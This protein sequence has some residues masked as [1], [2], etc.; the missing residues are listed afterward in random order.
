MT[1][2]F[3]PRGRCLGNSVHGAA[4]AIAGRYRYDTI[5]RTRLALSMFECRL[6]LNEK[7][8]TLSK[9]P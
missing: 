1:P 9:V 6:K 8:M 2:K 5:E 7:M 4:P 3:E